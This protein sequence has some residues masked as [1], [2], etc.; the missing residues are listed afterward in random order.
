LNGL[1]APDGREYALP[2]AHTRTLTL[3]VQAVMVGEEQFTRRVGLALLEYALD[4]LNG[5]GGNGQ[6]ERHVTANDCRIE[7]IASI[8]PVPGDEAREGLATGIGDGA[9]V[10]RLQL[11]LAMTDYLPGGAKAGDLATAMGYSPETARAEIRAKVIEQ[12]EALGVDV[13]VGVDE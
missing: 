2:V 8:A 12:L 3:V 1:V 7:A 9:L 11:A 6:F 13:D 5:T 4:C 10:D